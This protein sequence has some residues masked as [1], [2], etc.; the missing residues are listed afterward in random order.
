VAIARSSSVSS[1][2]STRSGDGGR[3]SAPLLK[4]GEQAARPSGRDRVPRCGRLEIVGDDRLELGHRRQ[5]ALDHIVAAL[6]GRGVI[7]ET[8]DPE[9]ALAVDDALAGA[10]GVAGKRDA[11]V[12]LAS[13]PGLGGGR[14]G[15][16]RAP[17][18][19]ALA[20][21]VRIFASPELPPAC[22]AGWLLCMASDRAG[23]RRVG[24]RPSGRARQ[25]EGLEDPSGGL[26]TSRA[27]QQPHRPSPGGLRAGGCGAE[28]RPE[29]AV[30][31][32]SRARLARARVACCSGA[33][34]AEDRRSR[35]TVRHQFAHLLHASGSGNESSVHRDASSSSHSGHL[36][37][38]C[39]DA[40]SSRVERERRETRGS[41]AT[42]SPPPNGAGRTPA[43]RP[44]RTTVRRARPAPRELTRQPPRGATAID[45]SPPSRWSAGGARLRPCRPPAGDRGR[46]SKDSGIGRTAWRP[47]TTVP[48]C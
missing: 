32:R 18:Q 20:G 19:V 37:R 12:G 47:A 38:A 14:G 48:R 8:D 35:G 39:R 13:A 23:Q 46:P 40:R 42:N 16:D 41:I 17:F 9:D 4:V 29:G 7:D 33:G 15:H 25:P 30:E 27:C 22:C 21:D 11:L 43:L 1:A 28:R 5:L 26:P 44:P 2:R 31:R 24:T 10:D 45:A 36:L 3:S 34:G 6:A